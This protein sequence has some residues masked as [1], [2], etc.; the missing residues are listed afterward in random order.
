[1]LGVNRFFSIMR[2]KEKKKK[3]FTRQLMQYLDLESVNFVIFFLF[4]L[5]GEP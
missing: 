3:E 2:T 1:M 5:S 4:R